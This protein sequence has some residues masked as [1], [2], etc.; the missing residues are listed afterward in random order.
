MLPTICAVLA[1][2][3]C[4]ADD[5]ASTAPDRS[6]LAIQSAPAAP[7][8]PTPTTPTSQP[9]TFTVAEWYCN[10]PIAIDDS[11]LETVLRSRAIIVTGT[12][13][14]D[15]GNRQ[16]T[17][18]LN[19]GWFLVYN[20]AAVSAGRVR[21]SASDCA[22][23]VQGHPDYCI[24]SSAA[25]GI[26]LMASDPLGEG[27]YQATRVML[28]DQNTSEIESASGTVPAG[29]KFRVILDSR[30]LQYD[31]DAFQR[32]DIAVVW[33]D[34]TKRDNISGIKELPVYAFIPVTS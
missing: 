23:S 7:P 12:T 19:N 11:I 21:A 20:H 17:G 4:G 30:M 27:T 9:P 10:R 18:G 2:T 34:S 14:P 8:T 25:Y 5:K 33:L 15:W 16:Y 28:F 26:S 29:Q 1:V 22:I 13:G 31:K 6:T 24:G 3:A 32:G